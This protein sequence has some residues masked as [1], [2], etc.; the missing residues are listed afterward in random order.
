MY[1][2]DFEGWTH[3]ENGKISLIRDISKLS[4]DFDCY[5]EGVSNCTFVDMI[6]PQQGFIYKTQ[7]DIV[8]W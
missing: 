2:Q 8:N 4:N 5:P 1:Y 3:Q 7:E 6:D